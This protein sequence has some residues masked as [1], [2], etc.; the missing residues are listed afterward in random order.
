MP[1]SILIVEDD[2]ASCELAR[3]L[4]TKAGYTTLVATDGGTGVRLALEH[5]P[6]LVLCDVQVPVM[7]GYALAARLHSES[8]WRRVPLVAVTALS[9]P[10]DREK[11]LTAGFD[12][13]L[14]KPI[15]PEIFVSQVEGFLPPTLR[16][17]RSQG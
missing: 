16:A 12:A 3:Y 14:S 9:M 11:A 4:L 8:R 5:N 17:Y 6:D 15:T 7:N 10:G 2:S 13:Y 1:A